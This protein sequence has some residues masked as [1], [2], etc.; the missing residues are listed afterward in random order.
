MIKLLNAGFT[1]LRKNK[2]FW[3]L[4]IFS[5]GLALLM[6]YSRYSDM[7]NYGDSIEVEQL[8]FNYST[9]IGIVIAIFTS[10]F[11]GVEYS[12]GVIRNKVSIGH[13]RTNVYLSN[14]IIISITS[15]FS[16]ILFMLV[17][18]ALG[19]PLFGEI[20]LSISSFIMLIGCILIMI[21][22]TSSIFTFIAMIISNKTITA[23]VSIMLAFGMMMLALTNMN[24]LQEP[25][26]I[27]TAS[28]T[29]QET[30]A[31]EMK[32]EPNPKYPS[33]TKKKGC[34]ILLDIN[35]VGQGFQ[36]A[37]GYIAN[38]KVLPL[39]SLGLIV[40]FTGVGLVLFKKKELK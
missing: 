25:K 2:L 40:V 8:I 9:S 3:I 32:Q 24:T 5:I 13:K 28:I 20:T 6:I 34:Q 39:Y 12:D 38:I 7:K 4:T 22:S 15:L 29:N 18:I 17:I 16:Y 30:N 36:I 14:L 37:D 26:F 21:I 35:P 10:L 27:E 33:E 19:I 23:V 31:F 11:L 1:R